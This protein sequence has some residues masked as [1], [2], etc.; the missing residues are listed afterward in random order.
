M[1]S[2]AGA[3]RRA[4]WAAMRL[5]AVRRC[6]R[7]A[8][9]YGCR[10]QN[11]AGTACPVGLLLQPQGAGASFTVLVQISPTLRR[12]ITAPPAQPLVVPCCQPTYV[13]DVHHLHAKCLLNRLEYRLASPVRMLCPLCLPAQGSRR[14]CFA[15]NLKL[16]FKSPFVVTM[17]SVSLKFRVIPGSKLAKHVNCKPED[18]PCVEGLEVFATS[19]LDKLL[20]QVHHAFSISVSRG[21]ELFGRK[22][23]G[24]RVVIDDYLQ[25]AARF[26]DDPRSGPPSG[27]DAATKCATLSVDIIKPTQRRQRAV[28][29]LAVEAAGPGSATLTANAPAAAGHTPKD[30][31]TEIRTQINKCVLLVHGAELKKHVRW[32]LLPQHAH[33]CCIM[34]EDRVSMPRPVLPCIVLQ[35]QSCHR[36]SIRSFC[37]GI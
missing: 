16:A 22:E 19:K 35:L 37:Q 3:G 6:A 23:D 30:F 36:M 20:Q 34:L 18:E 33:G 32:L 25:A 15:P 31:F 7:A 26:A 13:C 24:T 5:M 4:G 27:W 14:P 12:T 28:A 21:Q 1:P 2:P 8:R 10:N 29:S 9:P 11:P 17:G